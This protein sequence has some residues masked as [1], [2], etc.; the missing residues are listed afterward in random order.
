MDN[1]RACIVG[2]GKSADQL[3]AALAEAPLTATFERALIIGAR[4]LRYVA[5]E[6]GELIRPSPWCRK[7]E[8][9]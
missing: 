9:S 2:A 6:D 3:A 7:V 4:A 1:G 8:L 5:L